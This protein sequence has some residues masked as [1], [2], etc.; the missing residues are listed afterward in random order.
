MRRTNAST[1]AS[2]RAVAGTN[3][4]VQGN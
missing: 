1:M 3:H 4:V 2:T